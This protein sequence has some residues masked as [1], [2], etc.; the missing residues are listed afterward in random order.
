MSLRK[1]MIAALAVT[2][3]V[4]SAILYSNAYQNHNEIADIAIEFL[5]NGPTFSYDGVLESI[6]I[7]DQY[8]LESYPEQHIVIIAFN[9]THAGWGNREGTFCA[10]VITP[11]IIKITIVE[12]QVISAVIDEKWDEISQT[13][14]IPEEYLQAENAR[15][16]AIQ[17][18]IENHPEL[19]MEI[20]ECWISSVTTEPNMVGSS[21]IRYQSDNWDILLNYPVVQYP[22]Y[23]ISIQYS[24]DTAFTWSGTVVNTRTVIEDTFIN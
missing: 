24:G 18:I 7:I 2:I 9:T 19:K 23:E 4:A 22:N 5:V 8:T 16:L 21:T 10:Q 17:Y 14:I 20:P 12:R 3:L 13:Q 6:Q 11:H 15:D 1:I